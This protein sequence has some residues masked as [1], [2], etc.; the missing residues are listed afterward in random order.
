[1]IFV[2]TTQTALLNPRNVMNTHVTGLFPIIHSALK[3]IYF[4]VKGI[5]VG[6]WTIFI[7]MMS[8]KIKV[9][10]V[11]NDLFPTVPGAPFKHLAIKLAS[12][13]F[14]AMIH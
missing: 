14:L 1:M 6:F 4:N 9:V 12:P 13:G 3:I 2:K 10:K 11:L 8:L 5:T 7:N